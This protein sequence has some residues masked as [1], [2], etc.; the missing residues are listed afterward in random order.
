MN[1]NFKQEETGK[2]ERSRPGSSPLPPFS[3]VQ[4]RFFLPYQQRWINDTSRKRLIE[5]SRQVGISLCTAY[6]LVAKTSRQNNPFD[7]WVSSRDELQACLFGADCVR[8]AAILRRSA[9]YLGCRMVDV[10]NNVSA[11]VIRLNNRRRIFCLTSNPDAQAGKRG[12]R[13]FDEFALNLDNRLL[14]SIGFPGTMWGGGLDIISTHRGTAN[15]FNDLV[16][17][18]RF[19][20]NPKGFSLHRVTIEDACRDGLLAKLQSKWREA[21]PA[22]DRLQWKDDDFLQFMRN[23][24]ADEESWLQEF[25]CVPGDDRTAFL[26]YELIGSCEL[27]QEESQGNDCQ[28]NKGMENNCSNSPAQDVPAQD[29]PD[30]HSPDIKSGPLFA[31]VD[32][33]REHDLTVIWVLERIED[34]CFTREVVCLE[35]ATFAEQEERLYSILSRPNFKR[36]C[37]DQTGI[38]RQFAERALQR[39]GRYKVEGI[40]FTSAVKEDL[41]Y[42]TRTAFEKKAVRIPADKLIRSDLRSMRKEATASGNIRFTGERTSNGHADRFWGLALALHAAKQATN[43]KRIFA[44]LI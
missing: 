19:K 21:D 11:H 30:N 34:V 14:Y 41:A 42:T 39:F 12:H 33:G 43:T 20:G 35:K 6:D 17:E 40:N 22:D 8:W 10:K 4:D 32:V 31:G 7:A 26:S 13:V 23:Q 18:A 9:H 5:K 28:G 15:F 27:P 38:G 1:K 16:N 37:I 25:M 2:T 3:P 24:C 36:C 29:S 44:Q